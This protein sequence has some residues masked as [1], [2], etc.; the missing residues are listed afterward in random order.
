MIFG[1]LTGWFELLVLWVAA[2]PIL[3]LIALIYALRQ[4]G[5]LDAVRRRM[6]ALSEETARLG[7][8]L[9]ALRAAPPAEPA[10]DRSA[11][12]VVSLPAAPSVPEVPAASAPASA[13]A[14]EPAPAP[15][16]AQGLA[17]G[18]AVSVA[19]ESIEQRL[20]SRWLLWLG[21][22]TLGLGGLFLVKY[23]ANAGLLGP[24]ARVVLGFLFGGALMAAGEWARRHSA[25]APGRTD[26]VPPALSAGGVSIAYTVLFAAF[27][28]YH[29]LPPLLAFVLLGAVS[30]GAVLLAVPQGPLVA[31]LGV[32]GGF[33]TPALV[34]SDHPSAWGLFVYLLFLT[35]AG[36]TML[37]YT[38]ALWL[39]AASLVGAL[40]WPALWLSAPVGAHD[41]AAVGFYLVALAAL[42]VYVPAPALLA[43]AAP[44][45]GRGQPAPAAILAWATLAA[46]AVLVF[47][48]LRVD[49][50]GNAALVAL[51][52][53]TA[54]SLFIAWRAPGFDLA[55]VLALL[56]VL[57]G[58]AAWYMPRLIVGGPENLAWTPF[59]LGNALPA[60][61]GAAVALPQLP[62]FLG[63]ALVFALGFA[64]AGHARLRRAPR[65]EVWAGLAAAAPV[66]LFAV[67]YWR[68]EAFRLSLNWALVAL[69]L[70]AAFVAAADRVRRNSAPP[71]ALAAYAAAATAALGLGA[72]MLL[73]EA[74][75]TVALAVEL[76]VLGWIAVR[77]SLAQ[78]RCVAA[79]L[80]G[81]VLIRLVAN[82]DLL[83]YPIAPGAAFSWLLYG[84][85][86]PALACFT[87]AR[88]FARLDDDWLVSLLEGAALAFAALLATLEI[89]NILLG[90]GGARYG[91]LAPSLQTIVWLAIALGLNANPAWAQ[92]R[93][94]RWGRVALSV[95]AV[96]RIVFVLLLWDNPLW[97][98]EPV[99]S[100][101]VL[102]L[103]LL[104]YG[105]PAAL[106][107]V[108][109]AR[110]TEGRVWTWLRRVLVLALVFTE[111]SLE[112]RRGFHGSVLSGGI[113]SDAEWYSYSAAWLGFACVLLLL[114]IRGGSA[115]VRYGALGVLLLTVL[116]VFLFDAAALTGLLRVA[117]FFGLGLCLIGVGYLYQ[118]L[119]FITERTP[120]PP[121]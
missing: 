66:L 58:I 98:A 103:M 121:A 48:L 51:F 53:F 45:L 120:A 54:L 41:G 24:P 84:Y 19:R 87:A 25:V 73:R 112:V 114:G 35:G 50:Y 115:A 101:P 108:Q 76:P 69:A 18:G 56:P 75:L 83:A 21:A 29:L 99:G 33:V 71:I 39:G 95:L 3:A 49:L 22:L 109:L 88:L 13:S 116:K 82:P 5:M 52:A 68:V 60:P 80:L 6:T 44:P 43:P 92:R 11:S 106:L 91:L 28:L 9:A 20:T 27:D 26:Y 89:H 85:G 61:S 70:A 17:Q 118:R 46:I 57:A 65:P 79:V 72:A 77:L 37:R 8:E 119:V 55:G 38:G 78:L 64:A 40:I 105:V 12:I 15:G 97:S 4:R 59:P 36:L 94:A 23:A 31:L 90:P 1:F 67:A 30:L 62:R 34:P 107:A 74:W 113:T 110:G 2:A 93:V 117:S 111:L 81:V 63:T 100:L 104:A 86:F 42:A 47:A 32:V 96:L 10:A 7:R 102:N 16:L 14:P